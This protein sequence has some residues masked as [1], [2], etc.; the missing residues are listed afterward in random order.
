M[1]HSRYRQMAV[2]FAAMFAG[3][4]VEL[5]GATGLSST[6]LILLVVAILAYSHKEALAAAID[7]LVAMVKGKFGG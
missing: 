3:A 5:K 4:Y 6:Y 7:G 1:T 2:L